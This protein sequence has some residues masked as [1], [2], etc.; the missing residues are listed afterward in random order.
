MAFGISPGVYVKKL[1]LSTACWGSCLCNWRSRWC[2]RIKVWA[3]K[4]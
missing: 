3:V 2:F 4:T 1:D